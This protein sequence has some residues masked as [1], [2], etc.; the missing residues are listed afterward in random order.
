MKSSFHTY[1]KTY[2]QTVLLSGSG[3]VRVIDIQKLFSHHA[4][5][6]IPYIGP[7]LSAINYESV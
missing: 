4:F 3:S 2:I 1:I 7:N 6:F 5:H